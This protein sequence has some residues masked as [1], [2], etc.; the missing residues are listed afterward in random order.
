[1]GTAGWTIPT[2]HAGELPLDGTHLERYAQKFPAVEINSS[3]YRAHRP[4]TY[5]RWALSAPAGFRFAVKMPRAI[6][7]ERGLVACDA[8]VARFVSEIA[9]LGEKLGAILAQLPPSLAHEADAVEDFFIGLRRHTAAPIACEPRHPT[10]F[11]PRV[12]ARLRALE[13][14]RVAADP[15]LAEGADEPG[16]WTGLVYRRLHGSPRVYYSDY[17]EAALAALRQKLDAECARG[18]P[19]WCIFDNTAAF[20]AMGNALTILDGPGDA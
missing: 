20:A 19:V 15:A 16:G 1:V 11:T 3:F 9:G 4:E 6:T 10:W 8:L 18:I 14:A 5:E 17:D 7:H 12:E 2:R 13:V